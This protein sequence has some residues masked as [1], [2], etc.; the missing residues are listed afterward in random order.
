MFCSECGTK[1]ETDINFCGT[2]GTPVEGEFLPSGNDDF[3]DDDEDNINYMY[4]GRS[5]KLNFTDENNL[6]FKIFGKTISVRLIFKMVSVLLFLVL[7]LPFFTFETQFWTMTVTESIRG[8]TFHF[9][10][11]GM[12]GSIVLSFLWIIPIV[13]FFVFRVREPYRFTNI[14]LF[15]LS[16]LLNTIGIIIQF[17]TGSRFH[18]ML[19]N[20]NIFVE[21][22]VGFYISFL[23]YTFLF[24]MSF[25]FLALTIQNKAMRKK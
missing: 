16:L 8:M 18:N 19:L 6:V 1:Y 15:S 3:I 17:V 21:N 12:D 2:C 5:C 22:A 20:I 25:M 9:E 13:L 14:T 10:L 4:F 11:W 24:V 7:L 23:L